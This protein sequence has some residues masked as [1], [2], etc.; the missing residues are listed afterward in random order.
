[1]MF[2][3]PVTCPFKLSDAAEYATGPSSH[4]RV[5]AIIHKN[6]RMST[7]QKKRRTVN[8]LL[9]PLLGDSFTSQEGKF[10]SRMP[11]FIK[12]VRPK[13]IKTRITIASRDLLSAT[14]TVNKLTEPAEQL[15]V[16]KT[17]TA[18]L[19]VARKRNEIS[20]TKSGIYSTREGLVPTT[21]TITTT[22][23]TAGAA[24]AT[25]AATTTTTTA[26]A[27]A[28]AA[29]T[30]T[31]TTTS[32]GAAAATTTTTTTAGAAAATTTTTTTTTTTAGAAVV[33]KLRKTSVNNTSTSNRRLRPKMPVTRIK[34]PQANISNATI[35]KTSRP[36]T[37]TI[38]TIKKP[39]G[40]VP[41]GPTN[42]NPL[43]SMAT[44]VTE[45]SHK[46]IATMDSKLQTN[47]A[48]RLTENPTVNVTAPVTKPEHANM[49]NIFTETP[50]TKMMET[51]HTQMTSLFNE[52][53]YANSS[54]IITETTHSNMTNKT[55]TQNPIV[56]ITS[57]F[58]EAPNVNITT[59]FTEAPNVNITS[60]FTEAPSVNIT[61]S[62]TEA[63]IVN[64]TISTTS[65]KS[66][67]YFFR[68]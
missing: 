14:I 43:N 64:I 11:R 41:G 67:F 53:T 56:N 57:S 16:R 3:L 62:F 4:G 52:T 39:P 65:G 21:T 33:T 18:F 32:A 17:L 59:S 49:T 38:A 35:T 5:P 26:V 24:A 44:S 37:P 20:R 60:S 30:T 50:H 42:E 54:S 19:R 48:S 12:R 66:T 46:N 40:S 10:T 13:S 29:T 61:T 8:Q 22:T 6:F 63:P 45:M 55:V 58:T 28:A 51:V 9:T 15:R 23:T 68:K 2:I 7:I 1:M 27:A 25:T 36:F 34:G 31:T 47:I